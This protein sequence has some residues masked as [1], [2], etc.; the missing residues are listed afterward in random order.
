MLPSNLE[1]SSSLEGILAMF[2]MPFASYAMPSTTPPLT[3][4][5]GASFANL[6]RT[7]AGAVASVVEIAI[8]LGPSRYGARLS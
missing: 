1:S 5:W 4:S 8:A 6:Q 2:A 3:S 7:L